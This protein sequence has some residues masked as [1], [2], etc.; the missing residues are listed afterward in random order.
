MVVDLIS[1]IAL[2]K[3]SS[4]LL[5]LPR[6]CFSISLSVSLSNRRPDRRRHDQ[7]N[8]KM[9]CKSQKALRHHLLHFSSTCATS[10]KILHFP[11]W[12]S[13]ARSWSESEVD[14]ELELLYSAPKRWIVDRLA[15]QN[16][17]RQ[18]LRCSSRHLVTFAPLLHRCT[19]EPCWATKEAAA[20]QLLIVAAGPD[21][22]LGLPSKRSELH[23]SQTMT[24]A[25]TKWL[26][27]RA[28]PRHSPE[29]PRSREF[30]DPESEA[31]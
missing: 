9:G 5:N 13:R 26:S 24:V 31:T 21:V 6:V 18:T 29:D 17:T 15:L 25:P 10:L 27:D 14:Q 1:L 11:R 28:K 8:H 16:I 2:L 30:L 22:R 4:I 19:G 7:Q 3:T 20:G 12:P 23:L